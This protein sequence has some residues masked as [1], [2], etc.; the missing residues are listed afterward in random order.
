MASRACWSHRVGGGGRKRV[1]FGPEGGIEGG[2]EDEVVNEDC[3]CASARRSTWESE[4]GRYCEGSSIS[5]SESESSSTR[6]CDIFKV[7]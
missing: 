6:A 4:S 7:C 5:G 2:S 1:G 3:D